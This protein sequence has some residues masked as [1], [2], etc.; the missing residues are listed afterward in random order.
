M[1]WDCVRLMQAL[2]HERFAVVGHDR[3]C[4]VAQRAALDHPDRITQL[5]V[6]D[7]VPIGEALARCGA[8]FASSWWHWF[9]YG[10]TAKP[11][12]RYISLDPESWYGGRAE[13]MGQEAY[14]DY[15]EAINNPDTV[16]AMMEDYRAGLTIDRELEDADKAEGRKIICPVLMVWARRDDM[17]NLY[18]DP[19]AIWREWATDVRGCEIDSG[20]HLAEEAPDQLARQLLDFL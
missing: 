1:A 17:V 4:Y 2:G 12:E 14:E 13:S 9:F 11:A 10:Q 16:R 20:H 8:A 5:A 18:G 15:R 19:V 7:G 3:G 6:L